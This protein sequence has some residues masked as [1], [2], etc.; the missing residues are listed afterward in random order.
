MS[1]NDPRPTR[2]ASLDRD[3]LERLLRNTAREL[4][5]DRVM[6]D[7]EVRHLMRVVTQCSLLLGDVYSDERISRVLNPGFAGLGG[8]LEKLAEDTWS[9]HAEEVLR[10]VRR[11]PGDVRV[12]GDKALFD[13]GLQGLREV[14]GYDLA[15][16]GAQAYRRAGEV[17][18]LL[19]EDRRLTQYFKDNQLLMLPLEEEVVFLKQ[20]SEKFRLYADILKHT[21]RPAGL[22]G[23]EPMADMAS[24]VPLMAAA[25]E[26][27]ESDEAASAGVGSEPAELGDS[28][29]DAARGELAGEAGLSK[30]RLISSYERTLLFA[31]LDMTRLQSALDSTVIDQREAVDA[32]CDDF[33]LFGAGTRD[34]RKPP[35]YFLVGPTGV[36]KNYLVESLVNLLQ[37]VWQIELPVLTI[38]GPNYTYPSDINELRGATRGFIRSDEEGLLTVFHEKSSR[39]PLGVILV[40]EVE[41]AH[42][43]FLTFFLSIL[44]RGTIT[45]NR[46]AVLNFANCMMF[47]TSNLGYSDVQQGLRPI[48]YMDEHAREQASDGVAR[49]GL[50][51]ELRPEFL[52]RVRPIH[53]N[54][55]SRTSSERILDLELERIT[56]RYREVHDLQVTLDPS[57]RA[58]LLRLGFS[59][60]YGARHLAST[61]ELNC[62]VGISK[63]ILRD[64]RR[65][66]ADRSSLIEWLRELRSGQRVF[67]A[68]EVKQR[69]RERARACLDYD[70]LRVVFRGGQ[71]VYETEKRS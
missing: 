57:A 69:V 63:K 56:K 51:G 64:D 8:L 62:N 32:L 48:G 1:R 10:R 36:G 23:Q 34:P 39:A 42:P 53:F 25:I 6:D 41:K 27:L 71:F 11:L 49:R 38:E 29:V 17:L 44:D 59:P 7:I 4:Y 33:S 15:Q 35:A 54:R 19:A 43:H 61:L 40:D 21:H 68:E 28:Y 9:G 58:E 26:A 65:E 2:I 22:E 13:H 24:R 55:L 31:S 60:V 30:E 52:N 67:E 66:D 5:P 3:V 20:C 16:L 50:R 46:G 45:D 37:G 12:V 18:E 14:K 70:T 47:F